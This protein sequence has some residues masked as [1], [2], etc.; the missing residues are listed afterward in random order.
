MCA[1]WRQCASSV[2]HEPNPQWSKCT[3]FLVAKL[4]VFMHR[5]IFKD[6]LK[7]HSFFHVVKRQMGVKIFNLAI[8]K[9]KNN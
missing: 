1:V 5:H 7:G 2:N 8:V 6:F 4:T 3:C 9:K